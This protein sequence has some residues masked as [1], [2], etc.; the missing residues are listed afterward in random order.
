MKSV[1]GG[2]FLWCDR[3]GLEARCFYEKEIG[4]VFVAR[5]PRDEFA[6]R[7][8]VFVGYISFAGAFIPHVYR[9]F[10]NRGK[11]GSFRACASPRH[12]TRQALG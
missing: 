11:N 6:V 10:H 4:G 9:Y 1:G 5:E 2:V 7:D 3:D 8:G 12:D